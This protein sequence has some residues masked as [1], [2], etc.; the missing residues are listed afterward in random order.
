MRRAFAGLL[1]VLPPAAS[2]FHHGELA[3]PAAPERLSYLMLDLGA[4]E[5]DVA[6]QPVVE[7]AQVTALTRT[8]EPGDDLIEEAR[9]GTAVGLGARGTHK[10]GTRFVTRIVPIHLPFSSIRSVVLSRLPPCAAILLLTL[11]AVNANIVLMTI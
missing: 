7:L 4:A 10:V 3:A 1:P 6:Q 11:F 2:L 5:A 8:L 9:D